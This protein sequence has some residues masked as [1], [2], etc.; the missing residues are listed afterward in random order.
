M[1]PTHPHLLK[2]SIWNRSWAFPSTPDASF[3]FGL[4]SI[5]ILGAEALTGLPQVPSP[6]YPLKAPWILSLPEEP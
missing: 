2:C 5:T 1:S 3:T 6:L 4:F